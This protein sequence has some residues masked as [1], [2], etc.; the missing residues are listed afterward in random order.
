MNSFTWDAEET[1]E[2]EIWLLCKIEMK[3]ILERA[4]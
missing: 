4:F 1:M 3:T 2:K